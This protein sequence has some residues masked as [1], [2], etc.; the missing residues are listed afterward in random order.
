[1]GTSRSYQSCYVV[2]LPLFL[3]ATFVTAV[4]YKTPTI[5]EFL[6]GDLGVSASAVTWLMSVFTSVGIIFSLPIG[7]IS[8]SLGPRRLILGAVALDVAAS[9][10]GAF[11]TSYAVLLVT[12]ACEGVALVCVIAN[13]PVVIQRC[14]APARSGTASGIY[15]LGGMLGAVFG[16]VMTPTLFDLGGRVLLWLGYAVLVAVAGVLFAVLVKVSSEGRTRTELGRKPSVSVFVKANT[17][18]FYL[19]FALFQVLLLSVLAFAPVALQQRGMSPTASGFVSTLPMLL[20]IISSTVFGAV[21]DRTGRCKPL[22]VLGLV[23]MAA[24]T[25]VILTQDGCL[26]WVGVVAMGLLAM[27]V[28]TAFISAY[29]QV[30][31]DPQLLPVGMGVFMFVQSLGQFFGSSV[32][33]ALLGPDLANWVLCT[34]VLAG[35]G[36]LSVVAVLVCRLK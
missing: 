30:L 23:A 25:P 13:G 2:A 7:E 31:G 11:T 16:G 10:V 15:M 21:V 17:L 26:L 20:A 27:G 9:V 29:P 3:V 35:F 4:Q 36:A 19:A 6:A 14:V 5:V 32:P 33:A 18:V 12:R 22:L 34:G 1:M 28:P 24:A 8:R